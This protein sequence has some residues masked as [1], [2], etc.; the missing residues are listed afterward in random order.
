MSNELIKQQDNGLMEKVLIQGDLSQLSPKERISYYKAVCESLGLNPLTKPFDYIELDGKL[1]LYVKR[2]ATEQL[3][4]THKVSLTIVS[5]EKLDDVYIVT[6]RATM[7]D[8]RTDE[9]TGVVALAKENGE[10]TTAVSGKRY[11]KKDGTTSPITGNDLANAL[12]KCETKAKR[13]VTLSIIGL[14]WLDET[15]IDTIQSARVD[16]VNVETGDSIQPQQSEPTTHSASFEAARQIEQPVPSKS[17]GTPGQPKKTPK[18]PQWST[19]CQEFYTEVQRVTDSYF[20]NEWQFLKAMENLG[21]NW[22]FLNSPEKEVEAMS[23]LTDHA[24]Q[25]R[26]E[27]AAQ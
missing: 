13:R 3:R 18:K 23:A 19:A 22:S 15:E 9:S 8:G 12:M 6:A 7:P 5:R 1:L 27:K 26:Q 4:K 16:V 10:W 24:R 11:L 25:R 14:G 21:L 2:D 20:E 17:N